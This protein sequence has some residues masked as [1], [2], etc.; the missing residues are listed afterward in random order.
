ML[1][2]LIMMTT[3]ATQHR[4][5]VNQVM[6]VAASIRVVCLSTTNKLV[7]SLS[8]EESQ[9]RDAMAGSPHQDQSISSED[10]GISKSRIRLPTRM[11]AILFCRTFR[12]TEFCSRPSVVFDLFDGTRLGGLPIATR[13]DQ[14]N[15]VHN[16]TRAEERIK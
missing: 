11:S 5:C 12:P 8:L 1:I 9:Q 14:S 2:T 15:T 10:S 4:S 16:D 6:V 7:T 13:I 3:C